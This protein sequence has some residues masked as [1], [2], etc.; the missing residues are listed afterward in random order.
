M[1]LGIKD[2]AW[3]SSEKKPSA[4]MSMETDEDLKK[5][6]NRNM[7]SSD[8]GVC[9]DSFN[10]LSVRSPSDIKRES[11]FSDIQHETRS[12][13]VKRESDIDSESRVDN[14]NLPSTPSEKKKLFCLS[15]RGEKLGQYSP[16]NPTK[17]TVNSPSEM[18]KSS[19]RI[20]QEMLD[21]IT[22]SA[23]EKFRVIEIDDD[24]QLLEEID[25]DVIWMGDQSCCFIDVDPP[26]IPMVNLCD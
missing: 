1:E 8:G 2:K 10:K 24:I 9:L 12:S 14:N 19:K 26:E 18:C 15:P 6:I 17:L 5:D 23:G 22:G 20:K 3:S 13:N 4:K 7:K 16:S 21:E 11:R 25:E